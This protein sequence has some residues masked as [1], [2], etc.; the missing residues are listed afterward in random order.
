MNQAAELG[1]KTFPW[2]PDWRGECAAIIASGPSTKK[3]HPEILKDR[4]HVI[5]IKE[6]IDLCP[7]AEVIYGCEAPWWE[8][9]KGLPQYPDAIKLTWAA[10][11]VGRFAPLGLRKVDIPDK[12]CDSLLLDKP[13]TIGAGGN[14]GFQ[15]LNLAVQFGA[16]SILLVGFDMNDRAKQ[17]HYYGRNQ[18]P[19]AN[20]PAKTNFDRW[21]EA[22]SIAAKQLTALS[23]ETVVISNDSDL[24]CFERNADLPAVLERWGL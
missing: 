13:L 1:P 20:N 24:A 17:G 19:K 12:K 4:A 14:S 11:A 16:T 21:K 8:Y 6:T 5:A 7:F 10:D 15:A 9:R 18:W 3:M 22:F 2:W 23:I